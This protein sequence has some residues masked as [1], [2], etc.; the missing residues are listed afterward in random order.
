MRSSLLL[1]VLTLAV[2]P[3]AGDPGAPQKREEK[4][5]RVELKGD[6]KVLFDLLNKARAEAKLPPLRP[7]PT[8]M[9]IARAHS[10]NML[11]QKKLAHELDGKKVKQRATDAGY[12]YRVIAENVGFGESDNEPIKPREI[13]DG[14]MKSA[15]HRKN[16]LDK[17]FEEV[18]LGVAYD[19]KAG[20]YY[21]TQVF[22]TLD[23]N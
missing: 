22:G 6:E 21:F 15:P 2:P 10:L 8:L 7:H 9:K 1:A 20:V 12:D 11:K 18:G 4:L 13:H 23:R 5:A 17:R 19:R 16:I 14:W 3:A